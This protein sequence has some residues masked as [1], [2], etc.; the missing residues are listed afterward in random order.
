MGAFVLSISE[1]V[2]QESC[3]EIPQL[4]AN[5]TETAAGVISKDLNEGQRE[6]V[7]CLL[8]KFTDIMS[9]VPVRTHVLQRDIKVTTDEPLKTNPIR[10]NLQPEKCTS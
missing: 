1:A 4:Q 9:D 2:E 7:K 3:Y 6:E 8:T 10:S 5:Q